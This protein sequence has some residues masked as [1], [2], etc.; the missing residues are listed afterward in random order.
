MKTVIS[1]SNEYISRRTQRI[2]TDHIFVLHSIV[3]GHQ[4]RGLST[5]VTF[6][7]FA[8]AFDALDRQMFLFKILQL[9][10]DADIYFSIKSL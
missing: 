2:S 4:L 5:F 3:K 6:V 1:R 9:E 7:N 8:K 10:I